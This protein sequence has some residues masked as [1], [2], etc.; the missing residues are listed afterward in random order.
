[1]E[2]FF[3]NMKLNDIETFCASASYFTDEEQKEV[4]KDLILWKKLLLEKLDNYEFVD[5]HMIFRPP[6]MGVMKNQLSLIIKMRLKNENQS[7]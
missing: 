4:E 5:E 6:S 7:S 3:H 2:N 1:M